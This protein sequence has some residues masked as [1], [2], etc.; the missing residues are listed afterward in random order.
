MKSW[1]SGALD[2]AAIRGSVAYTLVIHHLC[3]FIFHT[4]PVDK[5]SLR[6][7]L[8]KSL[9]RDYSRKH[10]HEVY[11]LSKSIKLQNGSGKTS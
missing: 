10:H 7:K 6:N 3:S 1:N 8:V 9:L 5:L 4:H 11:K 2:R